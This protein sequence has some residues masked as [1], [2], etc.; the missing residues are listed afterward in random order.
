M[1]FGGVIYVKYVIKICSLAL[2]TKLPHVIV[3]KSKKNIMPPSFEEHL[4]INC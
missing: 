3:K 4:F 2:V 1:K